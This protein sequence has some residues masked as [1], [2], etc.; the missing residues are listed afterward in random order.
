MFGLRMRGK[1][2]GCQVGVSACKNVTSRRGEDSSHGIGLLQ[3]ESQLVLGRRLNWV[4]ERVLFT[5]LHQLDSRA[6]VKR[7]QEPS[8][9]GSIF[10]THNL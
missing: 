6:P 8:S 2:F 4:S 7:V 3:G 10:S 9:R 5:S 1:C